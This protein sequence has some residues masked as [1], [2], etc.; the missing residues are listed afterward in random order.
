M[1]LFS[2]EGVRVFGRA[3]VFA[4]L[5]ALVGILAVLVTP[6]PSLAVG[7]VTG[8]LRGQL[9]E[10]GTGN[11][12]ASA[13]VTATSPSGSYKATTDSNGR[14]TLI[15]LPTDT[16]VISFEKQG[17]EP[18]SLS[19]VS[20][21][22]DS[23]VDLG[24]V[25]FSKA[26]R[27]IG[28]IRSRSSTSAFQPSQTQ[29]TYTVSGQR[30][31]QALGNPESTDE[32]TLLQS[33]PGV[34]PTYDTSNG[35]GL[36]VRGSL[37]VELG[38]QFDGVPFTAPFF[39]ENGSQG[40]LNNLTGGSGGNIQVVSGA[41]DATQGNSGGGTINTIAPRGAYPQSATLDLEIAAP[42]YNHT[43]NFNDSFATQNGRISNYLAYSGSRYTPQYA[44][45]N[46]NS[47]NQSDAG[48]IGINGQYYGTS[49]I[50]HDD[51][52][53]NFV[54]RFGNNGNQS[55]QVLERNA[56][57]REYSGYG[58]LGGLEYFTNTN[59]GFLSALSGGLGFPASDY[60]GAGGFPGS[61]TAQNAYLAKLIPTIPYQPANGPVKQADE[62]VANPLNFLKLEYTNTL[63][64]STFLSATYYN[65]GLY[66]GGSAYSEYNSQGIFGV[67][68]S[69]IGGSRT[70]FLADITK[71][72]GNNQT[73]T[74]E[75]KFE[76]AKP[77]WDEQA[78][79]IGTYALNLGSLYDGFFGGDYPGVQDWY[80]PEHP[81]SPV[82]AGN[83]CLGPGTSTAI[84]A[85]NGK[86]G[87]YIYS[88]LLAEG[89]WTGVL[90]QIPN[91]GIDYHGTDQQQWGI[92]LRDQY[93]PI[94]KLHL[95]FGVRVDG[96]QNR[97]GADQF[98]AS[99]P[100]DVNPSKVSNAFLRPREVEPRAA[101]SFELDPNDSVRASY[102]RSTLF[103]FGQ[104]LG[105]PINE[106]G[107]SPL[108]LSL[109]AKDTAAAPACGSG[110]HGPGPGYAQN[111]GLD[112][113]PVANGGLPSYFFKCPNY[114][115]SIVSLYDQFFDAPDLGGYGPP[116]YNN[117]D[118]AYSHQF[119]KGFLRGWADHTTAYVR[120]GFNVEQNQLLASG[121][122][123][124]ITGQTSGAVFTTT[125]NGSERT[126][127]IEEQI[128]TPDIAPGHS[129]ISGY[130]TMD[131]I[132]EYTN[133]PPVA[134]GSNLPILGAYLLQSGE[135]FR[136][137][138][139]PPVTISTGFTYQMK[140]G[141]RITPSLLTN[142]G[143]A[144][145]VGRSSF[146]FI[147]GVLYTIP[148]DNFG[149][150]VPYA[151]VG[152]PGN[153]YNA[154]YYVDP[155]VP[156]STLKP[157]IDG[158]RGYNEPAIAG[159]GRTPGQAY[160][161][162]TFEYPFTK[163][164]TIGFEI[165]N[166]TN[167]VYTVPEDNTLYQPVGNGISGPQTGKVKTSLPYSPDYVTGSADYS[168]NNGANLPFLNGYGAGINF[169]VYGR[170]KI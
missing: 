22:G 28:N 107:V 93:S 4:S 59:S 97:F 41:G 151:G 47:L 34:I 129:G 37:A 88:T 157:N 44:P 150:N 158:S 70:G 36:S 96:E 12:I 87:C 33:V 105:T 68:Y 163:N 89:K 55:I 80:L 169:N 17:Y 168:V 114:A 85:T 116:T 10:T 146:G 42:W 7:G 48:N 16:Y 15:Q 121:P 154:S 110:T 86:G 23:T 1:P 126:F 19:G 40:F 21:V 91:F 90:P 104:T 52:L 54:F 119:S 156:G 108:L 98:A 58:G 30:V 143:Y 14:F 149:P 56:D 77:F 131:Y 162:L 139:I 25:T 161:N 135:Y 72:I 45:F 167:N 82:G 164:A 75:G 165:Y 43:L 109:P 92:G 123:N 31:T 122:P 83:P 112:Q 120:S 2:P 152:G 155:Q 64:S 8:S 144:F 130:A 128:T 78:P 137:G 32:A 35:A 6:V 63:N 46:V 134:G 132:N 140:N 57:I 159:N 20:V 113:N 141:L 50:T 115:V 99:T 49:L 153:A 127:G 95:D 3:R 53:D 66:N 69:E 24:K 148:E 18:I 94:P 60:L 74:L 79:G 39:D 117:Y 27:T 100:S 9:V 125:A 11:A 147:N 106:A 65:W 38:Y 160:L 133:T 73:I 170:F 142:F 71:T 111:P 67:D 101:V 118:L 76:N 61:G 13:T 81:G 51:W 84:E 103:F 145:G 29:D 124:P 138:F 26:L 102:G 136:A 62:T 166:L 5:L